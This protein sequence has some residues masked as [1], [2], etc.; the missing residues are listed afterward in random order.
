MDAEKVCEVLFDEPM[1]D[2]TTFKIGGPADAVVVPHTIGQA[3]RALELLGRAGVPTLVVGNGSNM[4]VGDAGVRGAAVLLREN[5]SD[6]KVDGTRVRAQ[7]G[8]LL[9]DVA[10]A[11]AEAG[12][13]GLEPLWGIPTTVGGACFMNAGAYGAQ[14]S[15]VLESVTACTSEGVRAFD[16]G[17]L[18]MGYRASRLQDEGM[19][20]L[21]ATFALSPGDPDEIRAAM[22]DY[23]RRREEKQPLD[24]PSAGSTFKRPPGHFAGKLIMDADLAGTRVGGAAVS[25]KHC[26]FIVNEGG[27]TASD[28]RALIELV[29][30]RVRERFDVELEPEVRFVGE[31]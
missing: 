20:V 26:G 17:E 14:T 8:A 28:V 12:L 11:A 22:Q 31:F 23:Q 21:E 15:D 10:Q 7:A 18:R 30:R 13:S 6:I 29:Q 9:R 5:L 3:A 1:S 27:A 2:H 24:L 4:L 25:S 16:V 19:A